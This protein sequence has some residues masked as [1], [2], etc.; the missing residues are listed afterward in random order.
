MSLAE[1]A[2]FCENP[3]PPTGTSTLPSVISSPGPCDSAYAVTTQFGLFTDSAVS[4]SGTRLPK[5]RQLTSMS[6]DSFRFTTRLD[7]PSVGFSVMATMPVNS[8]SMAG[9]VG[10][11]CSTYPVPGTPDG[12][13]RVAPDNPPCWPAPPGHSARPSAC[14]VAAAAQ[15]PI[16]WDRRQIKWAR[17]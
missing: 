9:S 11:S 8:P 3:G 4:H 7:L 15:P 5:T 1:Y 13:R 10:P 6:N 2:S 14:I 16:K 17:G 12:I